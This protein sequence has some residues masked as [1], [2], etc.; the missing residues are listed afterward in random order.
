LNHKH[1][2]PLPSWWNEARK[3]HPPEKIVDFLSKNPELLDKHIS[4]LDNNKYI[5]RWLQ[6]L[7]S[8]VSRLA[9][10][11]DYIVDLAHHILSY[12]PGIKIIL[13]KIWEWKNHLNF[14][15]TVEFIRTKI[16]SL[17]HPPHNENDVKVIEEIIEFS[18]KHGYK[19]GQ[20]CY[21]KFQTKKNQ[22][23]QHKYF[24]EF[25]KSGMEKLLA[26]QFSFHRNIFPILP[27][28]AFWHKVFVMLENLVII[29]IFLVNRDGSRIPYRKSSRHDIESSDVIQTLG[30]LAE[31]KNSGRRIF[32]VGNHDGYIGPYFVRSVIRR[33]GFNSL[34]KNCN[35]IAGP[36][37]FS[38]II[39]RNGAANVGNLFMTVP[40]QKTTEIKTHGLAEE[41][42]KT[43][44]RTHC[45]VKLPDAGLDILEK[46]DYGDFRKVFID[47]DEKMFR[48]MAGGLSQ[49]RIREL[50]AFIKN[51]GFPENM[52]DFSVEDYNLFKNIMRETFLLF[53]EGSR[54]FIDPDGA[55]VMKYIN[56][57]YMEAYMRPGDY[58]APISLVGGS[59]FTKGWRLRR[60]RFGI[61]MGEPVEVTAK[62]INNYEEEGI[63][64]MKNIAALPN[65][66]EIRFKEE[67]QF[68]KK[69]DKTAGK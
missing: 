45:M 55:Q 57:R 27:D 64:V 10:I 58:I 22:M 52:K 24:Q 43:A 13:K 49:A 1:K 30:K 69:K 66:K 53:P 51:S 67:I 41:L 15:E 56:P 48:A 16:Y 28:S 5:Y 34:T 46:L 25:C 36:R 14:R 62:M 12:L 35:T 68:K 29:D 47:G 11:A 65:I 54:S 63:T 2:Q 31:I 23:L 9:E 4:R 38:N 3:K 32:I 17:K 60:A 39:L 8:L 33:L 20:S 50:R 26:V 19:P 42:R 44:R 21:R 7:F 37:M 61:S 18:S 40:S 6:R 59:D